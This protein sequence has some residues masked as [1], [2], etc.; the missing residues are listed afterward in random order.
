LL[1]N[2]YNATGKL[3]DL[4][5]AFAADPKRF[6]TFSQSAP[7]VFADLSKNFIDAATQTLLFQLAREAG[8]CFHRDAMFAGEKI[9]TTEAREVWH[10]L[11]RKPAN[12]PTASA[13]E[14]AELA[15]VHATLDAVLTFAERV[16]AD[17]GITDVVNI[18]IGG[19]DL[20]PHMAV[21]ALDAFATT[22]KRLHFVSNVD[23]HQII[24]ND[25]NHDQRAISKAVVY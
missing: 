13:H 10:V 3:F 5:A 2:A 22:G 15:K 7:G 23:G 8:V 14:A 9:N 12:A 4:R 25:R 19:S 11:L 18:G 1:K 20:G 24:Y 16:R 21:L 17:D 6:E